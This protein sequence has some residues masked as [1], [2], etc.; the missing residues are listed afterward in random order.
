MPS[1]SMR[2]HLKIQWCVSRVWVG[3][4]QVTSVSMAQLACVV[5]H[6][7][8]VWGNAGLLAGALIPSA[9]HLSSGLAW[10]VLMVTSGCQ[11]PEKTSP[12]EQALF[13]LRLLFLFAIVYCPVDHRGKPRV[14]GVWKITMKGHGPQG[15][16][17]QQPTQVSYSS[18]RQKAWSARQQSAPTGSHVRPAP[19]PTRER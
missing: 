16:L 15:P 6:G 7:L 5:Q 10:F 11:Q 4:I 2:K 19:H 8:T 3:L 18:T 9:H 14:R 17:L 12:Q 1:V 13:K